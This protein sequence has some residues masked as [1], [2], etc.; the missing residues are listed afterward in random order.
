[1]FKL[2]KKLRQNPQNQKRIRITQEEKMKAEKR[3]SSYKPK[4]VDDYID[5]LNKQYEETI[6]S[7]K[8]R[9]I[10]LEGENDRLSKE[11]KRLRDKEDLVSKAI[12]DA[13]ERLNRIEEENTK[14]YR[15]AEE[16]IE[17]MRQNLM[18]AVS[19][20]REALSI[21]ASDALGMITEY[22]KTLEQLD[23]R[24]R[25]IEETFG[26]KQPSIDLSQLQHAADL[27]EVCRELGLYAENRENA[28]EPVIIADTEEEF[29][30]F[31]FAKPYQE[32]E[33][34]E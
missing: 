5:K 25:V 14:R 12:Y 29:G 1:M 2:Q 32:E 18:A 15:Q 13:T 17:N 10:K 24:A 30:E 33:K 7:L 28:P 20:A 23:E 22:I 8:D 31:E 9:L 21:D 3:L 6:L 27:E 34:E 19:K 11:N 16:N 4:Y 26:M